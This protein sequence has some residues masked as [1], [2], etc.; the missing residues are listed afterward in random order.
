[1]ADELEQIG[2]RLCGYVDG[3]L[4]AEQR[5]QIEQHLADHP[6]HRAIIDQMIRHKSWLA[7]LPRQSAPQDLMEE[8]QAQLERES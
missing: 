7:E 2:A 1:M 5:A 4:D 3:M 6:E 8:F